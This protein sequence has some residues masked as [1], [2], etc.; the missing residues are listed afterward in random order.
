VT[1][2]TES[3][4]VPAPAL[5]DPRLEP[6]S[7]D[8]CLRRLRAQAVGRIALIADEGPV[9]VVVN[10][11]LIDAPSGPVIGVR[12][13]PGNVVD[14]AP[15]SV[16]FEIDGI[17]PVH[18]EGWSVLVRGELLH[19]TAPT[20]QLRDSYDSEPWVDERDSWLLITPWAISGRELH[21]AEPVW[22]F[23]TN[24]YL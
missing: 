12:T 8:E 15:A 4:V 24:E 10:Y 14:R 16:A 9:I 20:E 7:Q 23:R 2:S 19:L 13:R 17:D 11:R 1:K 5:D 18:H 6:L 22:T 21:G 3:R